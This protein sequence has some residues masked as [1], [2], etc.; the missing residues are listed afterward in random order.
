MPRCYCERCQKLANGFDGFGA[1]DRDPLV[2]AS[3]SNEWFHFVNAILE[4]VNQESPST[5]S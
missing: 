1:N 2:E 3:I 4:A 5:S